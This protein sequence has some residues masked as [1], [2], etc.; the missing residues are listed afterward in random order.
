M[1]QSDREEHFAEEEADQKK[2]KTGAVV[3]QVGLAF[4]SNFGPEN[5]DGI[6][7]NNPV[8][9]RTVQRPADSF[10]SRDNIMND[11]KEVHIPLYISSIFL[12]SR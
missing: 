6:N 3:K 12:P 1:L 7:K 9:K 11:Q 8:T 2:K 5:A 4:K 10:S